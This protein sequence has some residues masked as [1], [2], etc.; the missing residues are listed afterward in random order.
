M[1]Q[2]TA[3][4]LRQTDRSTMAFPAFFVPSPGSSICYA[5]TRECGQLLGRGV[6]RKTPCN[7][8]GFISVEKKKKKATVQ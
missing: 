1:E 4:Y 3:N 2:S 8:Q 7:N 5:E 6:Y